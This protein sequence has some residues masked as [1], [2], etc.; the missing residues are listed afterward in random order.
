MS[1]GNAIFHDMLFT[2][3][4]VLEDCLFVKLFGDL[5]NSRDY[6]F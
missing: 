2:Y 5:N 4:L 6:M 1:A 3:F